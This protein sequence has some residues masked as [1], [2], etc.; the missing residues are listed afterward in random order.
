MYQLF[1]KKLLLSLFLPI[2]PIA[3]GPGLNLDDPSKNKLILVGI[4]VFKRGEG[5]K[6]LKIQ[7]FLIFDILSSKALFKNFY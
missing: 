1:L 2:Y 4:S 5:V 7:W 6:Y 3:A